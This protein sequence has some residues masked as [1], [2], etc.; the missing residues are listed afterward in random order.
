MLALY[1]FAKVSLYQNRGNCHSQLSFRPLRFT[2][3]KLREKSLY[4][5]KTGF[6]AVPSRCSGFRRS[7]PPAAGAAQATAAACLRYH[8]Y[9]CA[10][11]LLERRD[12]RYNADKLAILL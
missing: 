2:Q 7:N 6:L 8:L 11:A 10:D 4:N 12:M 5:K 9:L 3:G 1:N